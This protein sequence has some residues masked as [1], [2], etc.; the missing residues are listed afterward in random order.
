MIVLYDN[1]RVVVFDVADTTT[2]LFMLTLG[3]YRI[4][5]IAYTHLNLTAVCACA[6]E[7]KCDVIN[8]PHY[9]SGAS[10]HDIITNHR[11]QLPQKYGIVY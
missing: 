6:A 3:Y 5:S 8:E 1:S 7:V 4:A 10:S 11:H 9:R 2:Y